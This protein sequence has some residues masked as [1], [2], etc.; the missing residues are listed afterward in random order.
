M[1]KDNAKIRQQV[2]EDMKESKTYNLCCLKYTKNE[3]D[4]G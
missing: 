3:P 1:D 2:W 4:N